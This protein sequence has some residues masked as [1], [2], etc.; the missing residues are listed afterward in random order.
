M[1]PQIARLRASEVTLVAIVCL[2]PSVSFQM[3]PQIAFL[4]CFKITLIAGIQ[5]SFVLAL[6]MHYYGFMACF[7]ITLIAG[8][9]YTFVFAFNMYF[10]PAF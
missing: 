4:A 9:Q 8:I 7:K 2:F 1:C 3:Y 5:N 6:N 10:Q